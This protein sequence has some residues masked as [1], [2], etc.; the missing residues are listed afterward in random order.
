MGIIEKFL[1]YFNTLKLTFNSLLNIGSIPGSGPGWLLGGLGTVALSLYGL[2]LGR[3]RAVLSLLSL[4]AAYAI[5]RLFPYID[6]VYE[7]AGDSVEP[8]WVRIGFFLLLYGA[9]FAIFNLS[10]IRKRISSSEFYLAGVLAISF[11]QLSFLISI[12]FSF[13]PGSLTRQW[14]FGFYD[15]FATRQALFIWALAPLPV[16]LFIRKK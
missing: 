14:S 16:L 9:I 10:F 6:R 11:L 15:Y 2:S 7:L 5:D 1:E 13:L 8:H 3:T 12:L 4:Y